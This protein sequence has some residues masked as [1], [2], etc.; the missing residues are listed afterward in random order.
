MSGSG[1]SCQDALPQAS[2]AKGRNTLSF[3][4]SG[5]YPLVDKLTLNAH[6]GYTRYA[7]DLR[8]VTDGTGARIGVPSFADYKLGVTHDLAS[9]LSAAG[10]LAGATRKDYSGAIHT[11]SVFFTTS[12]VVW[13]LRRPAGIPVPTESQ[14]VSKPPGQRISRSRCRSPAPCRPNRQRCRRCSSSPRRP[15]RTAE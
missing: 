8:N 4:L 7:S 12:K 5:N 11:A 1:E 3:H 10:A 9:G 6:V 15:A 14:A 2:S 13:N